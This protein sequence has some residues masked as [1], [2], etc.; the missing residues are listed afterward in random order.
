MSPRP[1]VTIERERS[2]IPHHTVPIE[3]QPVSLESPADHRDPSGSD[4]WTLL[5][6]LASNEGGDATAGL[7]QTLLR[8]RTAGARLL[9]APAGRGSPT[10][11]IRLTPGRMPERE[12]DRVCRG[13]LMPH[14]DTLARLLK[15]VSFAATD[16]LTRTAI[17]SGARVEVV[18]RAASSQPVSNAAN[19]L[20]AKSNLQNKRRRTHESGAA[21]RKK[22]F[23]AKQMP[24]TRKA[25]AIADEK[26]LF[27]KQMPRSCEAGAVADENLLFAKQM[28]DTREKAQVLER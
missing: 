14:A 26:L 24:N 13:H 2:A 11:A 28:P 22:P 17:E 19:S 8:L 1:S 23:F 9:A 10:L 27:A 20:P 15:T 3:T 7:A 12:Y 21:A 5:I 25:A 18:G 4:R 6:T 16:P